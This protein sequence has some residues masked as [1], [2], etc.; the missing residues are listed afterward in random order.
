VGGGGEGA[1]HLPDGRRWRLEA[2]VTWGR[3][4]RRRGPPQ[5]SDAAWR[6]E[7]GVL[8]APCS[9]IGVDEGASVVMKVASKR[10]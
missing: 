10:S 7:V 8:L 3:L 9:G 2:R 1:A 4:R 5:S 6:G